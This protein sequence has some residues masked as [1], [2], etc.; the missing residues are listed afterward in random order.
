MHDTLHLQE[1]GVSDEAY[2]DSAKVIV[3]LTTYEKRID[4]VY[5]T[6]ESL[7]QQ[8]MKPNA[9]YLWL[10][11]QIKEEDLPL[12][13]KKQ[14]ARGLRV[15]FCKD[16]RSYK[17]LIPTL[18]LHPDDI[19]IT[20]DD[21]VL[22]NMDFVES[23]VRSYRKNPNAVHCNVAR[24]INIEN[25]KLAKYQQW[26]H[27]TKN[28]YCGLDVLPIGI[29]GVLYPSHIFSEEIF[30]EEMFMDICCF[31]DDLWFKVMALLN[32]VPAQTTILDAHDKCFLPNPYFNGKCLATENLTGRNDEQIAAL[33]TKYNFIKHII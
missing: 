32:N 10:S 6:I 28:E 1:S 23:L 2:Y 31:G 27:V 22:Y 19:I 21:D 13:L 7:L 8:T 18:K 5:L 12:T 14:C 20:T 17:K 25:G 26:E 30:N 15:R 24:K 29:G 16:I 33:Q 3:S 9:I 4:E 11:D